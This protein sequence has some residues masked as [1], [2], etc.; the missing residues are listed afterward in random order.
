MLSRF[1]TRILRLKPRNKVIDN[2][3]EIEMIK[4]GNQAYTDKV[5]NQSIHRS[6]QA[7]DNFERVGRKV[8]DVQDDVAKRVFI[9]TGQHKL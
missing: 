3:E 5:K 2:R 4:A 7:K 9:A 8:Y 1:L 6:K